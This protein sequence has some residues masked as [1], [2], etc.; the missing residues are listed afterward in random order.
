MVKNAVLNGQRNICGKQIQLLRNGMSPAPTLPVFS[1]WL[2][3]EGITLDEKA[4]EKIEAGERAVTDIELYA[5][6]RVLKV[7]CAFLLGD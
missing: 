3:R 4:I 7:S 6:A 5:I 2:E 1:K